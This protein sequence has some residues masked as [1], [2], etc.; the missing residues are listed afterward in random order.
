MRGGSRVIF[1]SAG[2]GELGE[3]RPRDEVGAGDEVADGLAHGLRAQQQRLLLA[4]HM[5]QAVGEDVTAFGVAGELHLVDG[6][7]VDVGVARHRLDGAHVVARPLGLDLF[8]AGDERDAV[9]ADAGDDLV[10]N[11]ARQQAQR[12]PD[13]PG[14]VA[15]HALDGKMRLARVGRPEH[16]RHVANAVR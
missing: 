9:G 14:L 1:F 16:G 12:Q 11:L 2:I 8:L 3:A 4:A 10:I 6:E 7:E 15:E 5:Q 13:Q